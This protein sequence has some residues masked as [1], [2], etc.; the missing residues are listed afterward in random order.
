[1][2]VDVEPSADALAD[3]T[4]SQAEAVRTTEGPLLV[5]AGAGSGKTRVITRRVAHLVARG[6]PPRSILAITF[7]NK[8]AGEMAH[9]IA[10]LTSGGKVAVHTFHAFAARTLRRHMPRLGR[11][12]DFTILDDAD[13]QAAVREALVETG[14]D[15]KLYGPGKVLHAIEREKDSLRTPE[16]AI[17]EAITP[18]EKSVSAA[19]RYYQDLLTQNNA[20]DFGE[21][22]L[23]TAKLLEDDEAHQAIAGRYRYLLID[24]YQDTNHAQYVMARL[25]ARDHRNIC[26]TGDANQAIYG[27]RGADIGNILRF[28][29]DWPDAKVVKLE[30][31]FRSTRTILRAANGLIAFNKERRDN[32]LRT[33]GP[34]G[35][36]IELKVCHDET[37]EGRWIAR[38]IGERIAY[39]I[40]ANDVAVFFRAGALSRSIEVGLLERGIPFE[41]VGAVAFYQRR[42]VKDLLAYLRLVTNPRDDFALQRVINVPPRGV[43]KTTL[44]KVKSRAVE[45]GTSLIEAAQAMLL[46]GDE[47]RG[48]ARTGLDEAVASLRRLVTWAQGEPSVEQVLKA[49][50]A[51]IGY[52]EFLTREFPDDEQDRQLNVEALIG[53]AREF[54]LG[55]AN[56]LRLQASYQ[57]M[58]AAPSPSDGGE[59]EEPEPA[60]EPEAEV[61]DDHAGP[62]FAALRPERAKSEKKP[63]PA[64]PRKEGQAAPRAEPGSDP[65]PLPE[66]DLGA[67]LGGVA[68]FLEHVALVSTLEAR[69]TDEPKVQLM[70]V[71]AAKGLE[72]DT[73]YVSGME[74][75]LFPH[76][77]AL[78]EGRG[79]EE[80]RR[81]AY[82]AITR[83]KRR[84]V[85]TRS[86]WRTR[87]GHSQPQRPSMFLLELPPE[88]F[89][90]AA[91]PRELERAFQM[92]DAVE[93]AGDDAGCDE[94]R[95]W[96]RPLAR[97]A[98]RA[99]RRRTAS[100]RPRPRT[101]ARRRCAGLRARRRSRAT[102]APRRS[103]GR[104]SRA[105]PRSRAAAA[106]PSPARSGSACPLRPARRPRRRP[107]TSRSA[108]G[109][110]TS[111]SV[112]AS[113]RVCAAPV[114][115]RA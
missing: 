24:E 50:V 96:Q 102:R 31:N 77:R 81:L 56:T 89:P 72:F 99:P 103:S 38:R 68:G 92:D 64:K 19:Y 80:E 98:A 84:L 48:R 53:A 109:C 94:R 54:D 104:T 75:G 32:V 14:T 7:T 44:S 25:L 108:S 76:S 83:A 52:R 60:A 113:C 36:P 10:A 74:D 33:D 62:L 15:P 49:I 85:L 63:A 30:D 1:M 46:T 57:A 106:R 8:A 70:T 2:A 23:L 26:A 29:E 28:E 82:V 65:G 20:V 21:L 47:L 42:E 22:L 39:G 95:P 73:V 114:T 105:S 43:G 34:E 90:A 5:L 9:R 51:E 66:E 58:P 45:N 4:P 111:T 91:S 88:V 17:A 112:A 78:E 71:H 35:D 93:P 6:V 59:D 13:Q 16:E 110:S 37:D 61:E 18:W 101:R 100:T 55:A 107:R 3:L 115:P 67:P 86:S 97:G 69:T 87:Q 40:P 12:S 11:R 27:W 41:V 79:L